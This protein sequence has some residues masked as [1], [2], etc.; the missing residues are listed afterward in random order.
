MKTRPLAAARVAVLA[1][2]IAAAT[3]CGHADVPLAPVSTNLVAGTWGG[4]NVQ[5]VVTDSAIQVRVAS[6]DGQIAGNVTPDATGQFSAIG[7]WTQ[8]FLAYF[9]SPYPVP[10]QISGRVAGTTLTF[11]IGAALS[12]GQS[13]ISIRAAEQPCSASHLFIRSLRRLTTGRERA[14]RSEYHYMAPSSRRPMSIR[15]VKR[16]VQGD[17]NPRR[18]GRKTSPRVRIR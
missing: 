18:R 13:A 15:P 17:S 12:D 4:N 8:N 9:Y 10:A 5:V 1:T 6:D 14:I 7:T 2:F 3:A 11:A 16:V